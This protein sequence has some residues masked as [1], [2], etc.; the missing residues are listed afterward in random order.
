LSK[1]FE[2]RDMAKLSILENK[3]N[4]IQVKNL[5]MFP[6]IFFNGVSEAKIDYDLS[7]SKPSVDYEIENKT[8]PDKIG[9]K[10]NFDRPTSKS[11]I[12]YNLTIDETQEND[13]LENRFLAL[14]KAVRSLFW[15]EVKIVVLFNGKKVH[16]SNE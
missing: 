16:E 13:Y 6:L 3:L 9:I 10:Y 15:K 12:E 7:V 1:E 2:I 4:D 5:R 11:M 8:D 14:E